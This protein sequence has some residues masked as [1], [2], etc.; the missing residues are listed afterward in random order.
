MLEM[1]ARHDIK[2]KT[3]TFFGLHEVP[4]LLDKVHTGKLAGKGI[5]IVSRE[6]QAKVTGGNQG[7][8]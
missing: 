4:K 1:V 2:V 5:C 3:T 8:V 6:E 7:S